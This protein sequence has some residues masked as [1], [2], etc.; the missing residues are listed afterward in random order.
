MI[1]KQL[2]SLTRVFSHHEGT[3]QSERVN[4]RI[5]H[6]KHEVYISFQIFRRV[7]VGLSV[8]NIRSQIKCLSL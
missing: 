3:V 6:T 2:T 4:R 5:D 8:S 7:F 1:N